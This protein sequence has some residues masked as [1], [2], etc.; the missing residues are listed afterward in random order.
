M[1]SP[2]LHNLQVLN[3]LAMTILAFMVLCQG[4][5]NIVT[6]LV[7]GMCVYIDPNMLYVI[8]ACRLVYNCLET[9]SLVGLQ[10]LKSISVWI[11]VFGALVA[12]SG[13]W[14]G[15]LRNYR[16][17]LFVNDHSENIGFYWYLFV[18]VSLLYYG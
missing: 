4:F 15:E 2:A 5:H 18:E 13:D 7:C 17:I 6:D 8:L 14:Q 9:K 10:V 3:H 16:N 1:I 11:L 12:M